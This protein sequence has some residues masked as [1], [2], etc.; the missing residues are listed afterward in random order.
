MNVNPDNWRITNLEERI[1][2]IERLDPSV[3]AERIANHSEEFRELRE[4][5]K[6][7]RRALYTF[8]FT[9]AAASI[10]FAIGVL[11]LVAS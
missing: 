5:I 4:E 8:A 11:Q 9:V 7:L 1:A 3:L 6:S 10:V 2:R